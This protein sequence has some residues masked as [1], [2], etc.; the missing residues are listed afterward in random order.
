MNLKVSLFISVSL[1]VLNIIL[2]HYYCF[3]GI[4]ATPGV[5]LIVSVLIAFF[6]SGIRLYQRII[7]VAGLLI[8]NDVGLKLYAAGSHDQVGQSWQTLF[9]IAG[10]LLALFILIVAAVKDKRET[11]LHKISILLAFPILLMIHLYLTMDLG[12]GRYYLCN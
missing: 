4:G 11:L 5:A 10:V 3:S 12:L 8:I 2:C 1:V 9:T 6:T 7:F